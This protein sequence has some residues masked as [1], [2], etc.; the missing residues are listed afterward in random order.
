M[1]TALWTS[2]YGPDISGQQSGAGQ[3]G[4]QSGAGPEGQQSVAGPEG[5]QSGAGPE[6]QLVI[7]GESPR[8][9]RGG[10]GA[11]PDCSSDAT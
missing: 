5:Q 9:S 1:Q 6:G 8:D 4:Q 11:S 3:E 10:G 7:T 2:V